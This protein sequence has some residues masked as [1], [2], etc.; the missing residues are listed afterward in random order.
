[1]PKGRVSEDDQAE[2][3]IFVGGLPGAPPKDKKQ[4]LSSM[5]TELHGRRGF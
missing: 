1:M 5:A 4:P 2:S 3:H